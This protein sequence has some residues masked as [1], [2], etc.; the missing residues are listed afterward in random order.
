M[1]S[2]LNTKSKIDVAF[3]FDRI[4]AG[5]AREILKLVPDFSVDLSF[6]SPPYFVGKRYERE[7][8]WQGWQNLIREVL[9][10]HSR[11]VRPGGFVAV[12]IGDILCW[13]D[14]AMPKFQ[15]ENTQRK[16]VQ[17]T[18]EEIL[19]LQRDYPA[20]DRHQL[21]RMLGC[22]EQTI[23]RRLENNNV[24]GG[25]SGDSTKIVVTGGM[26]S[27]WAESAGFYLYDHRIWHKDP[28][29]ATSR[30]HSNSYRAVDEFEHLY[31]FW[32][33][34]ITEYDRSRL[35]PE[36]WSDWG[37]RGVWKIRSVRQNQRHEAEFPEELAR[38]VI[39]LYSPANG[40]VIDPFVGSGTTTI[41]AKR[42]GRKWLGID[43]SAEYAALARNRSHGL[44]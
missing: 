6:W 36:E 28:C 4:Y 29:W 12:N 5:D 31:V 17:V 14:P 1:I 34:G 30:W 9:R 22:S 3:Q 21:A 25:K 43:L 7:L 20:A 35:N 26:L 10:E 15:A 32:Q 24:R 11:I 16:R 42:L 41:V 23:Q 19:K 2:A 44:F 39:T 13:R 27:E 33:P 38:R 8:T 40:V 18:R 37:S